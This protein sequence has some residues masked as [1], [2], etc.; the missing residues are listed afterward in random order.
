[1]GASLTVP[2]VACGSLELDSTISD[3]KIAYDRVHKWARTEK[4]PFDLN[5]AAFGPVIRKEAKGVVLSISPFNYPVWLAIGP[6]VRHHVFRLFALRAFISY[7]DWRHRGGQLFRAQ[8][9]R[10][11][12]CDQRSHCRTCSQVY[13]FRRRT[14][15]FGRCP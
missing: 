12:T 14:R 3:C 5:W 9:V 11:V 4:A 13:G 7:L 2:I 10:V 6:M 1:M 8:A 15:R